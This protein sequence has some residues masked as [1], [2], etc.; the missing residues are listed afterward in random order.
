M[1]ARAIQSAN[2]LA[3]LILVEGQ[4]KGKPIP[5]SLIIFTNNAGCITRITDFGRHSTRSVSPAYR[6]YT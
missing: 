1:S 2:F 3:Q 4:A 6:Q 5:N